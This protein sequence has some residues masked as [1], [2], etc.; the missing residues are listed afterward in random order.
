MFRKAGFAAFVA[1]LISAGSVLASAQKVTISGTAFTP[2]SRTVQMGGK[3]KW[4]NSTGKKHSIASDAFFLASWFMPTTTVAP[5]TTSVALT[6]PE[7]GTFLYHDSLVANRHGSIV[8]PMMLDAVDITLGGGVTMTLGTVPA[9]NGG[10][11]YHEVQA[12][13]NGGAW[14]L[15]STTGANTAGFKPSSVGTYEIQTRLHHALSGANTGW[16]PIVTL[17]VE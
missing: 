1:L 3:V 2:A 10:P 5:H 15:I 17:T 13:L 6:F 11:D 14:S 7:A 8:V 9:S 16:S 12:R 4:I